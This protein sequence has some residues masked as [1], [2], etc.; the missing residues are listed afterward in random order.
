MTYLTDKTFLIRSRYDRRTDSDRRKISISGYLENNEPEKRKNM[1][2]RGILD[3]RRLGWV[4]NTQW[5]SVD[6]ELLK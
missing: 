3:E 5:S 6:V 2:R 4:K 1:E